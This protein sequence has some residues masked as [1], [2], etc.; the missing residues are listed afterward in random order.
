MGGQPPHL[1][2]RECPGPKGDSTLRGRLGMERGARLAVLEGDDQGVRVPV[3]TRQI[4][5]SKLQIPTYSQVPNPKPTPKSIP[6][7]LG[8]GL[9]VG[10]GFGVWEYVGIWSLELGICLPRLDLSTLLPPLLPAAGQ[11]AR[12]QASLLQRERRTGARVLGWSSTVQDD[13]LL[14]AAELR[15]SFL[16]LIERDR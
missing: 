1:R 11:R 3:V 15:R 7:R 5:S 8:I 14:R 10:L 4:P 13:R 6:N 2:V 12:A 9:A 16:D